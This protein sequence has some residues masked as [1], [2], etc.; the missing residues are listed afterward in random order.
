MSH[1]KVTAKFG[2][3]HSQRLMLFRN[4]VTSL[5]KHGRIETTRAKA[6]ELKVWADK[7][8]TLGK[9]GDLHA[10]RQAAAVI[11]EPAVV[12]RLFTEIAP[13]MKDRN[14]GYTRLTHVGV[15]HG[16]NAPLTMIE[17][18]AL[19]EKKTAKTGEKKETTGKTEK[20]KAAPKK[21]KAKDEGVKT[22]KPKAKKAAKPKKEKE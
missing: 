5:L 11:T 6:K 17:L 16:D 12:K 21:A 2:R 22:E 1:A 18:V 9:R 19:P 15:R 13:L 4:L 3:D 20:A 14:V 10:R 7:M 8:V